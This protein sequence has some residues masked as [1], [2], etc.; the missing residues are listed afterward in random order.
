MSCPVPA[1]AVPSMASFWQ[2]TA[3][4][5]AACVGCLLATAGLTGLVVSMVETGSYIL[6]LS[7]AALLVS[8]PVCSLAFISRRSADV[9]PEPCTPSGKDCISKEDVVVEVV[10]K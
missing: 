10:V 5:T 4:L 3:Q 6:I 7:V 1:D 9:A 2:K 8:G